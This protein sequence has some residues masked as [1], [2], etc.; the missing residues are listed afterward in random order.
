MPRSRVFAFITTEFRELLP[1]LAFF[2]HQ[3][4]PHRGDHTA[5]PR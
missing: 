1:P 5:Y 4:Q 3:L 2:F